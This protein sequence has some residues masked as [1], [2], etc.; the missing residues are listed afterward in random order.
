MDIITKEAEQILTPEAVMLIRGEGYHL[1]KEITEIKVTNEENYGKACNLAVAN[2]KVLNQIESF[3]KAIVKPFNDQIKNINGMFKT[4]SERFSA[5]DEKIRKS[6]ESYQ[7]KRKVTDSIQNVNTD[8]GRAT[9]Q[10]RL[11]FEILDANAV[12]RDWCIPDEV[13][14][15]RAVRAGVLTEL[16][17]VKIFKK[18]VTAL[19]VS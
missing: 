15:G 13:R 7:S 11:D 12:P 6:I 14:I 2:K 8:L 16:S 5:N 17:G 9:I 1:T 3:R 18:K 19:S 10:E 4:I